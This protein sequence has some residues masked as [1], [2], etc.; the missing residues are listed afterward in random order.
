MRPRVTRLISLLWLRRHNGSVASQLI[1]EATP[2]DILRAMT[3]R[4]I[5]VLTILAD[6]CL[7]SEDSAEL[8]KQLSSAA[9]ESGQYD[10]INQ[11]GEAQKLGEGPL[12]DV[13]EV[14]PVSISKVRAPYS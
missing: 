10:V 7:T 5:D 1:N 3:S 4:R 12:A 14:I 11:L 2:Q 6:K 9:I 8:V 13:P